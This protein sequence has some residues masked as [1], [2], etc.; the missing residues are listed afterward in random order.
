MKL[1]KLVANRETL[2]KRS[3]NDLFDT[4]VNVLTQ[5]AT[6][7]DLVDI[8]T[9]E[10][11]HKLETFKNE[12]LNALLKYEQELSNFK[13]ELDIVIESASPAYYQMSEEIFSNKADKDSDRYTA[14]RYLFDA[15]IKYDNVAK[16]FKTR[17]ELYADWKHPG[18]FIRP[19]KGDF[20]D[21]MISNDPLYIVDEAKELLLMTM[22]RWTPE[23]QSRIRYGYISDTG[24]SYLP[25]I[26]AGQIGLI[27]IFHFFN[28]KTLDTV[29]QYL[30]E[31][32][33]LLKPGGA[34]I[35]TYNNCDLPDAVIQVEH[36]YQSY[37]PKSTLL[38]VIEG[39]GFEV[40]AEFDREPNVSWLEIKKPGTL[41][42]LRGGQALAQ[43]KDS[44][45]DN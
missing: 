2:K 16:E 20:V 31:C 28:Y 4:T 18:L 11:L 27:V 30:K 45:L 40:L 14:D 25:N 3:T 12:A 44:R 6:D 10:S 43:I 19:E 26:P 17:I 32:Y 39:L 13:K 33:D 22:N 35:F 9:E 5:L 41:T 15:Y 7:I 8:N 42:S 21:S 37:T 24:T 36:A 23:F 1:S 34:M 29:K 38:A